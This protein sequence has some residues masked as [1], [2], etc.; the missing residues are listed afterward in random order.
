MTVEEMAIAKAEEIKDVMKKEAEARGAAAG[1][2][3]ETEK[4]EEAKAQETGKAAEAAKLEKA[5]KDAEAKADEQQKLIEKP[6]DQLTDAQKK[7]KADVQAKIKEQKTNTQRRID[8]L[9]GQLHESK[10][11]IEALENDKESTKADRDAQVQ[12]VVRLSQEME[13]LKRKVSEPQDKVT[14]QEQVIKAEKDRIQKVYEEDLKLPRHERRELT[15]DE[16]SD[17]LSEDQV[18]AQ[19]WLTDRQIRRKEERVIIEQQ[20]VQQ[21]KAK[22]YLAQSEVSVKKLFVKFPGTNVK[23]RAIALQKEGKDEKAI[24]AALRKEVPDYALM[25]EIID[26]NPKL[27]EVA[28][29]AELVMAEMEKRQSKKP[30]KLEVD[31]NWIAKIRQEG[32]EAERQ[33]LASI[34][35]GVG[36]TRKKV[37]VKEESENRKKFRELAKKKKFSDEDIENQIKRMPQED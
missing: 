24:D 16:I 33:R 28:N 35:E 25:M 13:A 27:G 31:E 11:K 3:P 14:R 22:E 18:S 12:E 7:E 37:V 21:E 29:G 19:V 32:A 36:S 17:W 9:V 1:S 6:D 15:Q 5:V 10:R 4:T 34:D 2:S 26:E 23:D 30:A 20:F 8:E